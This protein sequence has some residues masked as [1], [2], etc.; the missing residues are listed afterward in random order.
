MYSVPQCITYCTI[1]YTGRGWVESC[2]NILGEFSS[3]A[4]APTVVLPRATKAMPGGIKMVEAL[5]FPLSQLP[6]R[7]VDPYSRRRLELLFRR[8]IAAA[9]P[10]STVAY[11]WPDSPLELVEQ[12]KKAGLLTI[13]QMINN[14]RGTARKIINKAHD[15]LSLG[16]DYNISDAEVDYED[17]ELGLYDYIFAP[18]P[19]VESSLVDAGVAPEKIVSTSFGWS[20]ARFKPRTDRVEAGRPLRFLYVGIGCVRK[21][22]PDLL[23]AWKKAR[24]DGELVIV[25]NVDSTIRE[26]V[27]EAVAQGSVKHLTYTEDIGSLYQRSDVFVF[28]TLEEGGPQ[29][30]LEAG[31]CGLPVVTTPMGAARLIRHNVNGLIVEAGNIDELAQALVRIANNSLLRDAFSKQ[32]A[33]DALEFTYDKVSARHARIMVDLLRM[34]AE[35]VGVVREATRS[36]RR[37]AACYSRV[38]PGALST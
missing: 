34:R 29:V 20:P 11:F 5:K 23:L 10:R 27:A 18:N 8:Q 17:R 14:Y 30:T 24:I 12:S 2:A 37:P 28:P 36:S 13:R 31:G 19:L 33:Q 4:I 22:L 6:W 25:G 9:D 15:R 21:G 38:N 1:P 35:S 16:S 32:I 7:L 3:E 26:K